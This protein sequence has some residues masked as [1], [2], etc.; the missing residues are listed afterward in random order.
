MASMAYVSIPPT[1]TR[2]QNELASTQPVKRTFTTP[3]ASSPSPA[4]FSSPA[5]SS[6][7]LSSPT[8]AAF[9][10][11][12]QMLLSSTLPGLDSKPNVKDRLSKGS[13]SLLTTRDPLSLP[14]I[15]AN[16]RRFVAR[17]G[18]IFWFQDRVEEILFWRH[19]WKATSVWIAVYAFICALFSYKTPHKILFP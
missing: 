16:F 8:N 1:A 11:L 13:P 3:P 10:L 9:S 18:P 2:L 17:S 12:P 7:N 15:S 14:T 4:P 19:G 5:T 6:L